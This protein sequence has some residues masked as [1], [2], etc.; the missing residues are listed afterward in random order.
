MNESTIPSAFNKAAKRQDE[1]QAI[2]D[3]FSKRGR[4]QIAKTKARKALKTEVLP[5]TDETA[6]PLF[7]IKPLDEAGVNVMSFDVENFLHHFDGTDISEEEKVEVLNAL[8]QIM[9]RFV[10][11]GFGMDSHSLACEQ[12]SKPPRPNSSDVLNLD[13]PKD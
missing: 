10:E 9:C 12:N 6:K 3:N 1:T 2:L 8:W 5:P 4:K 11:L 7:A 13:N